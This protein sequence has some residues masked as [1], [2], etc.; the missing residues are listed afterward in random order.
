M[1]FSI[2]GLC[3]IITGAASGIGLAMARH[4]SSQGAL[5]MMADHDKDKLQSEAEALGGVGDS[6]A[7]YAGD[8]R[9]KLAQA[10]LLSETLNAF[11]H[12]NLLLNT[13]V[14]VQPSH[15]LDTKKDN[16]DEMM[17][18]NI[19][20]TLRLSQLVAKQ[21]IEQN[22]N[23]LHNEKSISSIINISSIASKRIHS[24]FLAYSISSSALNQMT[25]TLAISLAP[26]GIRVNGISIGSVMSPSLQEALR[27]DDALRARLIE[28]TP[29][30]YIADASEVA[31]LAHFLA[32]QNAR[33]M[34]GQILTLDGG[35]SL[36]V[37]S[38]LGIH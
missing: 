19:Y 7:I 12:V 13:A 14:L 2:K 4:F 15:P 5:V 20:A 26:M 22:E 21:M 38:S 8:L 10:N 18:H 25:R 16:F 35:R 28:A 36:N 37:S 30:G 3:V 32:S 17:Q 23:L 9:E 29:L 27:E 31:K 24:D 1:S 6:L 11:D 33:F 34:T